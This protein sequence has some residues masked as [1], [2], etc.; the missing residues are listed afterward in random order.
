MRIWQSVVLSFLAAAIGGVPSAPGGEGSGFSWQKPHAKVLPTGGLEW[1]PE[2]FTFA[3]GKTVRYID[4]AAGSDANDGASKEKPWKHHPWDPAASDKAKTHRGPTSYV[5]KRGVV[6][7]GQLAA[8]ANDQ[9]T[10]EEP[11]RLTSDPSWGS[12][13]AVLC[14]SD[15]VTG[16]KRAAKHKDI[17]DAEKVWYADLGYAPRCVWMLVG[18]KATRLKLARTPNWTV[19]DPDDVKSEWWTWEQ[20]RWWEHKNKATINGKK[21]HLGIDAKHLTKGAAY[22]RDAIVRTEWGIVMGTPFPAKVE[23]VDEAKKA[24]AF[25]RERISNP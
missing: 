22:F 7:R 21:M 1:A 25:R 18:G 8:P 20:P 24:L 19:S 23:A 3:A 16:W 10:P 13:E 2:P 9:G 11:M 6:Y 17:P 5:F 15:P 12:G 14:G 4:F